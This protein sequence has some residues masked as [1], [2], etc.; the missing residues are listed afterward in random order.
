MEGRVILSVYA[1]NGLQRTRAGQIYF[2]ENHSLHVVLCCKWSCNSAGLG[3]HSASF[4]KTKQ[5][6]KQKRM[7]VEY[8]TININLVKQRVR[9]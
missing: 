5:K 9:Y 2:G 8:E 6:T 1:L 7:L 3:L 4:Q